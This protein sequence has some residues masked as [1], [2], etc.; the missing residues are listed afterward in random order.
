MSDSKDENPLVLKSFTTLNPK[1]GYSRL[2]HFTNC[3][4]KCIGV[5][6][7]KNFEEIKSEILKVHDKNSLTRQN[8]V[9]FGKN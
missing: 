4:K 2:D 7:I 9:D 5:N 6:K 8:I 1:M 3:I